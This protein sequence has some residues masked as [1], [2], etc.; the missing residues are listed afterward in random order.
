VTAAS[1]APRFRVYGFTQLDRI[2]HL[3]RL[4]AETR[5]AMKAVAAVLPFRVNQY[6]LDELI[7]WDRGAEDPMFQLT[8][9]QRGMLADE[10]FD[11]MVDLVRSGA[12]TQALREAARP[13]QRRMNPHPAGQ[14]T[15]N[16]PRDGAGTPL[17]G[18]QH[19]YRETLLFFPTQ[20]QTCHAY[21]TYCFRWAQFV[22]LDDL[23]FA[24]KEPEVLEA[25][26]R[27]HPE[28]S[29]VLFTGGDPMVMKTKVFRRYV[30]RL[31]TIDHVR[32]IRIGT[33]SVAY[34]PQRFVTD[35]DADDLLRLFEEVR[36]AGKTVALMGHYS[37]PVELSTPMAEEAVR[38]ILGAGA[39]LRTQAP[40]IRHVND[41][42]DVWATMWNR[43]IRLGA[44]PY[45]F[46][47]ERDT[48]PKHYFEVP[49]H[50]AL[51]IFEGAYRRV[52][53]LGR[54]VRGP[55][56]SC[57]PGKVLVDGVAEVMGQRVFV[58]KLIQA[59]D[60]AWVNRPFFAKYDEDATFYED[61]EP[62]FGERDFFFGPQLREMKRAPGQ[63]RVHLTTLD[64]GLG[65]AD[66]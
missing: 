40:L 38:R 66:A 63:P 37:H 1:A 49:L 31:L 35:G 10:D 20:G 4:D 24:S 62:A 15:M 39:V 2:P 9:P 22:G 12:D 11:A 28:I 44:V 25:Y 59:R 43:Q 19:K 50:R 60:P 42:A 33:K 14:M 54:T 17:D 36:A 64:G 52:S 65:A 27:A 47:V 61:L 16:V 3:D 45:Y 18:M 48:G 51:S 13:I 30:D 58:L 21:C 32:S 8:F 7:D 34:W 53:G 26:V 55:S 6:V 41:D 57:T 29:S 5:D 56:M 46:F 23:K